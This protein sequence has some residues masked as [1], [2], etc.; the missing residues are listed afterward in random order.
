MSNDTGTPAATPQALAEQLTQKLEEARADEPSLRPYLLLD[1]SAIDGLALRLDAERWP[2]R[3]L[4]D[5]APAAL[6]A[7][8]LL[9]DVSALLHATNP[10]ARLARLCDC[11]AYS[12]ALSLLLTPLDHDAL[13]GRLKKRLD[14]NAEDGLPLL[15]RY[16]DTRIFASALTILLPPQ[17]AAFLGV[18]QAW[19][20][21]DRNGELRNAG[22]AFHAH[23]NWPAPFELCDAQYAA[24]MEAAL[25]DEVA[26]LIPAEA[27]ARANLAPASLHALLARAI[28]DA[29]RWKIK[30]SP[31]LAVFAFL[32]LQFGA[33]FDQAAP[34]N[35]ALPRI[36]DDGWRL[37]Q[38]LAALEANAQGQG[39]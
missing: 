11:A 26:S 18:A 7:A 27:L 16:A 19:W 23:D 37:D 31:E 3:S 22:A 4:L 39:A 17:R 25:P 34:W 20:F 13:A 28:A 36:A 32:A 9:V 35:Q 38:V 29:R 5:S 8:P 10:A 21:C 30:A 6:A 12:N 2:W 14:V 1:H 33:G 15:L 24:F